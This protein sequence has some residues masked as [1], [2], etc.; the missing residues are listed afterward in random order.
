MPIHTLIAHIGMNK[1]FELNC[2]EPCQLNTCG[3]KHHMQT[4]NGHES[5][6]ITFSP[7]SLQDKP[8]GFYSAADRLE[9]LRLLREGEQSGGRG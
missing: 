7:A 2:F 9:E 3:F 5:M 1:V 8:E 4:S 6:Q